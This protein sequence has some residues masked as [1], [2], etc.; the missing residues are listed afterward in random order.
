[1]GALNSPVRGGPFAPG[2]LVE[3]LDVLATMDA[4]D[5]ELTDAWLAIDEGTIVG[6]GTGESDAEPQRRIDG[7]GLVAVPGLVNTHHHFFQTLTRVLPAAQEL[8]ILDWLVANYRIWSQV[9][10]EAV[11]TTARV[12]IGELLL[13][14]CTTSSDHL[15]VYPRACGGALAMLGAEITAARELGLRLQATRGAVDVSIPAGGGPPEEL[16]EDTD[17]VLES[18]EAAV[19]KFHDPSPGS[20]VRIGLAPCSLTISSERLL[21]ES[22]NLARRLG[23]TRHTHVA[24]V[25]EEEEHCLEIYGQRPVE[26]LDE[27]GWLGE[28]VW[29]AHVVHADPSDIDHLATTRT[30]VAHCPSSNMRL[31]SGI[32]PVLQML[33]RGVTV[34]LGVDGSASND[35]GNLLWEARQALL[36]SRVGSRGSTL[37][38]PR[39]ALRLATA[40][41]AE[42]LRRGDIGVLAPGM[43]A[44]IAF[45]SLGGLAGAGTENDPVAALALAPPRRAAHVMVDGRFAVWDGH[46]VV[47]EELIVHAHRKL[48]RRLVGQLVGPGT[49]RR[50]SDRGSDQDR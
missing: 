34:S 20:M 45:F 23:V 17:S 46:L 37:M 2:I 49:D 31:G 10:E 35:T 8:R 21:R 24:E 15:Y 33:E 41:G 11:Y 7:R 25:V 50:T 29:L 42:A 6:I 44:D 5:S 47:D 32:A 26:R 22:G 43:R 19:V 14:G 16:V 30:A 27:L 39:M 18:M 9:D 3:H 48:V 1:V 13:S 40:G 38:P 12:A 36:L 4:D 28:D